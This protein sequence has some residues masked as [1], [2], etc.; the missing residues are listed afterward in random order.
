[1]LQFISKLE[2]GLPAHVA[3]NLTACGKEF[4]LTEKKYG[5]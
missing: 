1:M 5:L 4:V 2:Y 3:F